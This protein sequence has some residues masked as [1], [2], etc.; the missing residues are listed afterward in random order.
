MEGRDAEQERSGGQIRR[1]KAEARTPIHPELIAK[2]AAKRHT[3]LKREGTD[4]F[5]RLL[6][7][8]VA[9]RKFLR[10][11]HSG[12]HFGLSYAVRCR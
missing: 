6:R 3:K 9:M 5:L 10:L 2:L 8:F 4:L 1:P 12:A 11:A 7:V